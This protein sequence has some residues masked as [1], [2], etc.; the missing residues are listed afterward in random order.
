M[1]RP[2]Y[3]VAARIFSAAA[4]GVARARISGTY[5]LNTGKDL[6]RLRP[7]LYLNVVEAWLWEHFTDQEHADEWLASLN[8]PP[9]VDLRDFREAALL[10][11]ITAGEAMVAASAGEAQWIDDAPPGWSNADLLAHSKAIGTLIE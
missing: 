10:A 8:A 11:A 7:E 4:S 5:T 9:S 3:W 6:D 1:V 2:P